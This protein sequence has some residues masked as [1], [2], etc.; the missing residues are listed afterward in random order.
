[1]KNSQAPRD[2]SHLVRRDFQ[3]K[4]LLRWER[5][6]NFW[7]EWKVIRVL[8]KECKMKLLFQDRN[9]SNILD[10]RPHVNQWAFCKLTLKLPT[11]T[12]QRH[13]MFTKKWTSEFTQNNQQTSDTE[14]KHFLGHTL[15]ENWEVKGWEPEPDSRTGCAACPL[16]SPLNITSNTQ[17]AFSSQT[18][19][20]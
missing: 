19:R 6:C 14:E 11:E 7:Q 5:C 13:K 18:W 4:T 9:P 2:I 8:N 3:N 10:S 16:I 17:T 12:R 15:T 1:M 20:L